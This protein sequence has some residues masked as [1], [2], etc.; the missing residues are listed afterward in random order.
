MVV[1]VSSMAVLPS[2]V[3]AETLDPEQVKAYLAG[4]ESFRQIIDGYEEPPRPSLDDVEGVAGVVLSRVSGTFSQDK[5]DGS[6]FINRT[7]GRTLRLML[8]PGII[9][10]R[11]FDANAKERTAEAAAERGHRGVD[12]L[13]TFRDSETG[14]LDVPD[15]AVRSEIT[16]WS[17]KSRANM[18][19]TIAMLD[20]SD[21][22]QDTGALAMVTLTLP[23]DWEAVAPDGKTF[24]GYVENFRK[25]WIKA[26]G[27]KWRVL[28]KLEFQR[29]GAPHM[30]LLI[31]VPVFV[32]GQRFEDWLS[33]S[34][35]DVVGA[36]KLVDD[37]KG[38]S[39]YTRH[40]AAG[41]GV[42]FSGQDFSDPRRIAMYFAGHSSKT[43]D[44]K[45]YQHKVPERWQRPGAGPGRFWGYSGFIKALVE[46]DLSLTD[47]DRLRRELRKLARARAWTI[48]VKRARGAAVRAK[49][50]P[51]EVKGY[52]VRGRALRRSQH[53]GG[54]GISGGFVLC[55]DALEVGLRISEHLGGAAN[56]LP[57]CTWCGHLEPTV[58]GT[59]KRFRPVVLV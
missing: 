41:T 43:T 49:L 42:D 29:R 33:R 5:F 32:K 48:A 22:A 57:G 39:E 11:S 2:S 28:W 20:F 21:W 53:G 45:E 47:Y 13:N 44:G 24:K 36:S 59:R 50:D 55:N 40:L 10:A 46:V 34:W 56:H 30:H 15:G 31:R 18:T 25:R 38:G 51:R 12:V 16:E 19:K 27:E 1:P 7:E 58:P 54:G 37:D 23:G 9:G 52:E 6:G 17:A 35:A 14:E 3:T 26:T 8:S 4:Y